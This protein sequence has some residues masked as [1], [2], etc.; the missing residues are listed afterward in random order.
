[1]LSVLQIE[2]IA[3]IEKMTV[4]FSAGLNILTG[5]TGAGKSILIDSINAVSGA[6]TSR[7]LI[8]TGAAYAFV[9]AVFTGVDRETADALALMGISTD[10]DGSLQL[11][12]KMFRDGKNLCFVGGTAVTV[13]MLRAAA[14]Q[15]IN[16][17]GQRDSQE[18]LRS[19]SHMGVLDRFADNAETQADYAGTF[20]ALT[21]VKKEMDALRLDEGYKARRLDLLNYQIGELEAADITDGETENLKKRRAIIRN[22]VRVSDALS[23]TVAAVLGTEDT[24]GAGALLHEAACHIA[25]V[26]DVVQG[27]SPVQES[28]LQAEETVMDA[29]AVLEDALQQL[30]GSEEQIDEIE[31][32]L[33]VLTRLTKK[34]GGSEAA[35]LAFLA[36][37]KAE[38]ENL[39]F[40]EETLARLQTEYDRLLAEAT[41]KAAALSRSR[42]QAGKTL[43][44]CVEEQLRQLSMP[45]VRFLTQVLPAPLS[46]TGADTVEFLITANPGEEP[47]ALG[48]VASGGELSRVMLALQTVLNARSAATLIFDEIDTGVSG[49]AAGRIAEK[50]KNLS[51]KNQVLCI[52]HSA[53]IAAFADRHIYLYKTVENGKTYTKMQLLDREERA[54]ELARITFG[55]HYSAVQLESARGLLQ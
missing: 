5:E 13:S 54:R 23:R 35:A 31:E 21:A 42:A 14:M 36:E 43:S 33:D 10:A 41:E 51:L 26:T 39:T 19:E 28:L 12:R 20:E 48:K 46:Q 8:R 50:L 2:N 22:A 49:T 37:A 55:D 18:L 15:L 17:H 34:Y 45:H 40:S 27:L 24:P 32:R 1:M 9:S 30:G 38:L 47:K 16:I 6:K 44:A 29:S 11:Q 53:R 25:S 7:E 3:I 4:D 52:T